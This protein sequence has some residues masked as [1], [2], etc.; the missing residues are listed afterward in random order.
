VYVGKRRQWIW[1]DVLGGGFV[2]VDDVFDDVCKR[3]WWLG[4][5][6]MKKEEGEK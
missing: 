3:M 6:K 5:I 2:I 4:K 1:Q